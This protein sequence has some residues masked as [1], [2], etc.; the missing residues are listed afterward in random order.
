MSK[1]SSEAAEKPERA[2][3]EWRVGTVTFIKYGKVCTKNQK[4]VTFYLWFHVQSS[5][6]IL[7]DK[8]WV[9]I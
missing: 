7:Y 9:A 4:V 8:M 2:F 1:N 3:C 5:I 6:M